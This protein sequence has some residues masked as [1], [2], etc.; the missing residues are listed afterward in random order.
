[1]NFSDLCRQEA[2]ILV[3]ASLSVPP[4]R[5]QHVAGIAGGGVGCLVTGCALLEGPGAVLQSVGGTQQLRPRLLE[6]PLDARELVIAGIVLGAGRQR[7]AHH[8]DD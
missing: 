3:A 2:N 5:K 6:F 4:Q 1:M 8:N 7:K